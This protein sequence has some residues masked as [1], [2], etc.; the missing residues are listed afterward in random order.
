MAEPSLK[1]LCSSVCSVARKA[2]D[3][4]RS[5]SKKFDLARVEK[6]GFND[7]VSYVD[8]TSEK[9]IAD[10]LA[11]LVPGSRFIG[12]EKHKDEISD[13]PT[14]IIDPLDGTTNF[15]H[16][17][18]CYAVSIGLMEE[19]KI[20]LGVVYEINFD[21][22]FYSFGSGKAF[23]NENEIRVSSI[24][25]LSDSLIVTG[26]PNTN[27][28]RLENWKAAFDYCMKNTHGVRRLG[29]AAADLA[30]VACGRFEAFF[31]YGLH[32][33]DVAGGAFI[34]QQAGGAVSDFKGGHDF[35]FG[36][37]II[38][39]NK[40]VFLEFQKVMQEKFNPVQGGSG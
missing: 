10:E 27:F 15:V 18:P 12:E 29:S 5:E 13:N 33:W 1:L 8:V 23:C 9:I 31:E 22:C 37:E 24:H 39:C 17:L 35:L 3:F 11:K 26:M 6:K 21:E 40:E 16:G 28:S 7:L 4:I 36:E 20:R 30:Y 2:G 32:A 19:R 14:W 34:V 25:K 38:A